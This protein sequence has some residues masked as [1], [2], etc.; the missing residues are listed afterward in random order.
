LSQNPIDNQT[1]V[2][3]N[4]NGNDNDDDYEEY[5]NIGTI[6]MVS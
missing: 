2:E 1:Q 3:F 5:G 4:G 6:D